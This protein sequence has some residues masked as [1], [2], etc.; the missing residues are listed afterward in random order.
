MRHDR[1]REQLA[2][3]RRIHPRGSS[4]ANFPVPFTPGR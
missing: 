1:A 2:V 3:L 4:G